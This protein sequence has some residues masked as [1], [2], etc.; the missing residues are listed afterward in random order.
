MIRRVVIGNS[1]TFSLW[2]NEGVQALYVD[3]LNGRNEPGCGQLYGY[4]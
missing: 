1:Q 4:F 3:V 2:L